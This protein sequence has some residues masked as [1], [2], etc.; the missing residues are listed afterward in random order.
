MPKLYQIFTGDV[1]TEEEYKEM[2]RKGRNYLIIIM[3]SCVVILFL[4]LLCAK[5][6]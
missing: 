2:L 6:I 4:L 3:S 5:I 1:L